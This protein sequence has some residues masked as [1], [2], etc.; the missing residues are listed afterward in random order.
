MALASE[1]GAKQAE[2]GA[3]FHYV[4][5]K[6]KNRKTKD[7]HAHPLKRIIDDVRESPK[8]AVGKF[9]RKQ[10]RPCSYRP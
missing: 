7:T 1:K 5:G 2:A 8:R 4:A 9:A 3:I 10:T 6:R